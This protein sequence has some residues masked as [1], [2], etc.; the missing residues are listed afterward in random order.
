MNEIHE[1]VTGRNA[2]ELFKESTP[3]SKWHNLPFNQFTLAAPYLVIILISVVFRYKETIVRNI[4]M[5]LDI[6][7]NT[8]LHIFYHMS[9]VI[10]NHVFTSIAIKDLLKNSVEVD[11]HARC[12]TLTMNE[13]F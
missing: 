3:R 5:F 12:I 11:S 1:N 10:T 9:K 8:T 13:P 2:T 4:Q 7:L 6:G